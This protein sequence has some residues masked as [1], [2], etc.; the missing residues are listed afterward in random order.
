MYNCHKN[1]HTFKKLYTLKNTFTPSAHHAK[2]IPKSGT[3]CGK[4]APK[5]DSDF[6]THPNELGLPIGPL[7]RRANPQH[8]R[9]NFRNPLLHQIEHPLKRGIALNRT[10]AQPTE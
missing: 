3:N 2:A 4:C 9:V 6:H 8:V 10:S 5:L 7:L 1:K